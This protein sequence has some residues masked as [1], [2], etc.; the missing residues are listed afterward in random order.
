MS[1]TVKLISSDEQELE[2][3]WAVAAMSVTITNMLD[4]SSPALITIHLF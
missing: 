3:P 4:G 2:V 1:G